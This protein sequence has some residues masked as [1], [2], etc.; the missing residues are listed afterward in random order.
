MTVTLLAYTTLNGGDVDAQLGYATNGD[1]PPS[2][3]DTL[4]EYAGRL[5]YQ[6]WDKPNEATRENKDYLA[7]IVRQGHFSVLEHASATFLLEGVSRSLTHE[8][9]RHRHGSYS[10]LSQR[11]VDQLTVSYVVPPDMAADDE[12]KRRLKAHWEA[13]QEEYAWHFERARSR[14]LGLKPARGVARA[15]M[16]E[17]TATSLVVTGN[18][19]TWRD[20]LGKRWTNAAETEIRLLSGEILALLRKVAPHTFADI[21]LEP[22]S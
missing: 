20:V 14:G 11:Y 6:S 19:R 18:L 8:L 13:C 10:Q 21:S 22:L 15:V 9:V 16:P 17:M 7:N 4:G 5:C 12:A 2:P 1:F 3:A